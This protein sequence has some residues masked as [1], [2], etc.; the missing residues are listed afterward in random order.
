MQSVTHETEFDVS[1]GLVAV[2]FWATWCGPCKRMT[3]LVQ[4]MESEFSTVKFVSLDID[5]VP[6]IA[7][8]YRIRSL[9]AIILFKN[10]QEFKRINGLVLTEPLRK[11]FK[12]LTKQD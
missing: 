3:P 1:E 6:S 7:Q 5:Q 10:G 12:E 2:K 9:P 8:K 11:I 4:K